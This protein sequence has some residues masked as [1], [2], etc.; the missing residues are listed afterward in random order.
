[1]FH[2]GTNKMCENMVA[3]HETFPPL[4]SQVAVLVVEGAA[5][6]PATRE[7]V[8]LV[9]GDTPAAA[10]GYGQIGHL[11]HE[12]SFQMVTKPPPTGLVHAFAV[13]LYFKMLFILP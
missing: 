6:L 10:H 11:S 4:V 5:V 13:T 8:R 7:Q 9:E 1:M 12:S 3:F 2:Y